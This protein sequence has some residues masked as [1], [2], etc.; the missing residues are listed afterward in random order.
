MRLVDASLAKAKRYIVRGAS[1]VDYSLPGVGG[2]GSGMPQY[3]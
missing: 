3:R 2:T 1:Y